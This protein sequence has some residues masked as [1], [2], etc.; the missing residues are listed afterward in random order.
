MADPADEAAFV[1]FMTATTM[2]L[3]Q[4]DLTKLCSY[5]NWK[6]TGNSSY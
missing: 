4:F 6:S 3:R 1:V 5:T 2:V